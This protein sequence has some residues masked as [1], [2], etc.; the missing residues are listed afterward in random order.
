MDAGAISRPRCGAVHR[1]LGALPGAPHW[2]GLEAATFEWSLLKCH[3]EFWPHLAVVVP[4]LL[5]I[6][7]ATFLLRWASAPSGWPGFARGVTGVN[8]AIALQGHRRGRRRHAALRHLNGPPAR[9]PL[10]V[11][12]A[13]YGQR[14]AGSGRDEDAPRFAAHVALV[15]HRQLELQLAKALGRRK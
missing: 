13:Q 11:D 12:A 5:G 10:V 8:A 14:R 7:V 3:I 2:P 6:E 9:H 4:G 1:W 15:G